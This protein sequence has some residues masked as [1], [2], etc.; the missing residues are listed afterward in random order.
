MARGGAPTEPEYYFGCTVAPTRPRRSTATGRPRTGRPRLPH[1][2]R[3][4]QLASR[5]PPTTSAIYIRA[6]HDTHRDPRLTPHH[7]RRHVY[8]LEPQGYTVTTD[9]LLPPG[10]RDRGPPLSIHVRHAPAAPGLRHRRDG[11]GLGRRTT[12]SRAPSPPP[13]ASHASSGDVVEADRTSSGP[14]SL[15]AAGAARP[16]RSRRGLQVATATGGG[17]HQLHQ[18]GGLYRPD[19][20]GKVLQHLPGATVRC[21]LPA[22]LGDRRRLLDRRRSATPTSRTRAGTTSVSG[23]VPR[24]ARHRHLLRRHGDHHDQR[25]P[26]PAGSR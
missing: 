3:H 20:R 5:A 9:A 16:P 11:N 4:R 26:H 2:T 8:L 15:L 13:H 14:S 6:E 24:T 22:E 10:H 19:G 12:G 21:A 25:L 18:A 23:S 17:P 1:G 7:H